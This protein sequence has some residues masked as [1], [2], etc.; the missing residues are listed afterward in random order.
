MAQGV[1]RGVG[2]N[3]ILGGGQLGDEGVQLRRRRR[4]H[5]INVL[6]GAGPAMIRAGEG[7]GE[8]VGN[9]DAIE[10]G[11]DPAEEV[12]RGHSDAGGNSV[13]G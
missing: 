7:A 4:D 10:Q 13:P 12:G 5:E 9:P 11:D 6:R 2:V 8:H 1:Q 3:V